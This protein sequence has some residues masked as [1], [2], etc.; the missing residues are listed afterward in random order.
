M[1]CACFPVVVHLD[2]EPYHFDASLAEAETLQEDPQGEVGNHLE[3]EE[4]SLA[5]ESLEG[6]ADDLLHSEE[7]ALAWENLVLLTAACAAPVAYAIWGKMQHN[8]FE[9]TL[10]ACTL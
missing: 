10:C 4:A 2:V 8:N 1:T 6:E 5:A 3:R 9:N 7:E